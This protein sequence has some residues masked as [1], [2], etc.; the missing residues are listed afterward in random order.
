MTHTVN[1]VVN[2]VLAVSF[3]VSA[4]LHYTDTDRTGPDPTRQSP[5]TVGNPRGPK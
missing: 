5:R 1:E 2:E 4:K 3:S